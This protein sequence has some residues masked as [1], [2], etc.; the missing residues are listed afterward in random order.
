[1]AEIQYYDIGLNLFCPQFRHPDL[2]LQRAAEQGVA[3]ILTGSDPGENRKI[4]EYLRTEHGL[5]V[6]GTAGLHPHNADDFNE[7]ILREVG[8]IFTNNPG[9]VA[10][11]ECG[12]DYNRMFSEKKAQLH[13]LER[14]VELAESLSA[15]MF[16][17]E[18]DAADD[19]AALLAAVP[20]VV[21]R[22]V[23]HCF[24]G[25]IKTAEKYLDM[26]FSIGVTGWIGDDR[27]AAELR[28]AVR[29][30]PKDRI[31]VETDAPYLTPRNI[32]G[33]GRTNVPENIVYV[34]RTLAE[35]MGISEE[36]LIVCARENTRRVFHI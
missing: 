8:Y 35:Y 16:L 15:P 10:V 31:L 11:G 22:S 26:G 7:E 3:C 12:L 2:I 6:Y 20:G 19:F 25:D 32:K 21:K 13:T 24:T 9:V 28:K 14:F 23:V 5:E 33:L 4:D 27:R 30:I 18:R 17:H 36:E 1:M 29:I 34:V